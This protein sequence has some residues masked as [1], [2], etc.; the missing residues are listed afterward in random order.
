MRKTNF[1]TLIQYKLTGLKSTF[2]TR[3][4]KSIIGKIF[5][6]SSTSVVITKLIPLSLAETLGYI[7]ADEQLGLLFPLKAS[8]AT[9]EINVNGKWVKLKPGM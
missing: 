6:L 3:F 9:D 8:L 4:N 1:G 2:Q 7:S 5:D